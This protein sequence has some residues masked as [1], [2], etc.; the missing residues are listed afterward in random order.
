MVAKLARLLYQRK[1]GLTLTHYDL[2]SPGSHTTTISDDGQERLLYEPSLFQVRPFSLTRFAADPN[3]AVSDTFPKA[4]RNPMA[5]RF[6]WAESGALRMELVSPRGTLKRAYEYVF[7]APVMVNLDDP[8]VG[9]PFIEP[10]D[11]IYVYTLNPDFSKS[12]LMLNTRLGHI[13]VGR[14]WGKLY[15]ESEPGFTFRFEQTAERLGLT[16]KELRD[17]L[18]EAL[19]IYRGKYPSA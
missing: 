14:V 7:S 1:P 13:N 3:C 12:V 10:Q 16:P 5:L 6:A 11:Q 15:I 2:G 18:G 19:S 9:L 17:L 4:E 8:Y